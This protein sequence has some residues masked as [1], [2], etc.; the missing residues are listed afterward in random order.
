GIYIMICI[1]VQ[2]AMQHS[3]MVGNL[4]ILNIVLPCFICMNC[5][6]FIAESI[7]L[8]DLLIVF[9]I[10]KVIDLFICENIYIVWVSHRVAIS[11]QIFM[12]TIG[13]IYMNLMMILFLTRSNIATL[14]FIDLIFIIYYVTVN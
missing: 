13:Y 3:D 8:C 5:S 10:C 12:I 1:T 9:F 6:F 4:F 11:V 2:T 7:D 14:L